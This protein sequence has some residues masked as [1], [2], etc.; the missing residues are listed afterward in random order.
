MKDKEYVKQFL[1]I[2][3][4][5]CGE[6]VVNVCDLL[7]KARFFAQCA[8]EFTKTNDYIVKEHTTCIQYEVVINDKDYLLPPI[9]LRRFSSRKEAEYFIDL[10]QKYDEKEPTEPSERSVWSDFHPLKSKRY[11]LPLE[12]RY[13]ILRIA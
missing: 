10:C 1:V 13:D 12:F 4:T 3:K 7:S 11:E 9:S 8:N 5:D 2:K 6:T